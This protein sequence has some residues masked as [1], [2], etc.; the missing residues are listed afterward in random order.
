MMDIRTKK[1][2]PTNTAEAWVMFD[3]T[4]YSYLHICGTPWI[5]NEY[6]PDQVPIWAVRYG[7]QLEP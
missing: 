5:G 3:G 7:R 2:K 4:P 1:P 6:E